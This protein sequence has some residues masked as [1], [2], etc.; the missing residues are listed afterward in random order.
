MP[1]NPK[2][3]AEAPNESPGRRAMASLRLDYDFTRGRRRARLAHQDTR[4]KASRG[5]DLMGY[6]P[7]PSTRR[8]CDYLM[9]DQ[10]RIAYARHLMNAER[11]QQWEVRAVLTPPGVR[12]AA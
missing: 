7:P 4:R 5:L 1:P 8:P 12:D 2:E 9:T 6:A 11:W 10:E 3:G